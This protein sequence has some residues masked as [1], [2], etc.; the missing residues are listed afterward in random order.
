MARL[1]TI[2]CA[3]L[4]A[5][6]ACLPACSSGTEPPAVPLG[7]ARPEP[8]VPPEQVGLRVLDQLSLTAQQRTAVT[9]LRTKLAEA[10]APAAEPRNEL[11]HAMLAAI[12]HGYLDADGLATRQ[13]AL[14]QAVDKARPTLLGGI[15]QL[16]ALLTPEQRAALVDGLASGGKSSGEDR[17]ARMQRLMGELDLT[18]A[19]KRRLYS[20][21]DE[22]APER[23]HFDQLKSALHEAADAFKQDEFD[24]TKL[25]IAH[26]PLVE[27]WCEGFTDLVK[28]M[29]PILDDPQRAKL[30]ALVQGMM[31]GT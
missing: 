1:S 31:Q 16:H 20:V 24:A 29:V 21:R 10:L 14:T 4:L 19:Q 11:V 25:A 9:A 5:V 15:N 8:A 3:A 28:V 17:R 23:E 2:V 6:A 7:G 13:A 30:A 22:L 18:F 12:A 26:V 27:L